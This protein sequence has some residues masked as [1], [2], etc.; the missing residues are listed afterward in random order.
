MKKS[1]KRN[2][3]QFFNNLSLSVIC[4]FIHIFICNFGGIYQYFFVN[5]NNFLPKLLDGILSSIIIILAVNFLFSINIFATKILVFIANFIALIYSYFVVHLGVIINEQIVISALLYGEVNDVS[6]AFDSWIY[7]YVLPLFFLTYFIINFAQNKLSLN[8][9]FSIKTEFIKK[10]LQNIITKITYSL[11]SILIFMILVNTNL[12]VVTYKLKT[13]AESLMPSYLFAQYLEIKSMYKSS[14][15]VNLQGYE[16]YKFENYDK[17]KEPLLVV[18]LVG[19]SLRSNRLA[20]NGYE[21]QTTP[22]LSKIPNLF[23]FKDVLSCATSTSASL[24]CMLTDENQDDWMAKFSQSQHQKK[25]S[26]AKI[27]KD[28]GYET[29]VLSSANKDSGIYIYK[30]FHTPNKMVMAS[31]LRKKYLSKYND[32]GDII[33][34]EE[35][36]NN[37]TKDALYV[38]GTRGSHRE[39]YSNYPREF[40][41]FT[42]DLGHSHEQIQN[43]YDNTVLYF[44]N[45]LSKMIEK[46]QNN[47]AVIFYASDHGESLGENGIFLHGAPVET[48][49]DEQ[50]KV[51][52]IVW[53]SD[54]FIKNNPNEFAKIKKNYELNREGKLLVKHDHFF[55]SILGCTKIKSQNSASNPN[56]NLCDTISTIK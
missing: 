2:F 50:R 34:L 46:L 24:L 37:I 5:I 15:N 56:L 1:F 3:K 12:Y 38:L 14:R 7:L 17:A 22:N 41:K 20:I 11:S 21:R 39:Y 42:P 55:H 4:V 33:L 6:S 51:P 28:L 26:V 32:F 40:A 31:E 45:F 8:S 25:Y 9:K 10:Y 19:E 49:P 43:S 16:Q 54:K 35:L 48:A 44:D 30:D 13:F 27:F 53:M 36:N 29:T 18:I 52:M 23:S 47:N